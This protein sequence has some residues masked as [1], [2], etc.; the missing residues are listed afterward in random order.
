MS[1]EKTNPTLNFIKDVSKVMLFRGREKTAEGLSKVAAGVEILADKI[2]TTPEQ[3]NWRVET[4]KKY[5]RIRAEKELKHVAN[6]CGIK[7]A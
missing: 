3:K 1:T 7:T 2:D 6:K 5:E 4:E